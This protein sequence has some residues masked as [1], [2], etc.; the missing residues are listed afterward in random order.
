MDINLRDDLTI[1]L[2]CSECSTASVVPYSLLYSIWR[3]GYEDMS[4]K[5]KEMAF[6]TAE[7]RCICGNLEKFDSPMFKYI[8]RLAFEEFHNQKD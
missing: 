4:D 6:M 3:Q 1:T 5:K 8:F 7:I 2:R